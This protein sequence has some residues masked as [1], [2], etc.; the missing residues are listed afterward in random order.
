VAK[1][2]A[3]SAIKEDQWQGTHFVYPCIRVDVSFHTV[4][5][6]G[7][8][9]YKTQITINCY[10]EKGSSYEANDIAD[11]V[12]QALDTDLV[13]NNTIKFNSI[14]SYILPAQRIDENTWL[15]KVSFTY[16]TQKVK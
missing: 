10:S 11:L 5:L 12:S 3:S 1:L 16:L 15:S 4:N 13:Y 6:V 14:S 9:L 7:C 8:S 2:S